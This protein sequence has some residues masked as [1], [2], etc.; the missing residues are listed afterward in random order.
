MIDVQG[1]LLWAAYFSLAALSL[2]LLAA[3]YRVVRGP[4]LPDRAVAIDF[5]GY[6]VMGFLATYAVLTEEEAYL[7]A[8][9]VLGLLAFLG[10]IALARYVEQVHAR[11]QTR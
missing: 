1:P 8:A 11:E 4:T 5:A 7:D 9:L 6:V 3:F 2:A 10:T